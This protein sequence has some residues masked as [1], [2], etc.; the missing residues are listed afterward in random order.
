MRDVV[1]VGGSFAHGSLGEGG[2]RMRAAGLEAEVDLYV[3]ELVVEEDERGRRVAV[4]DGDHGEG[5]RLSSRIGDVMSA[6]EQF[7]GTL[8]GLSAATATRP[9][10]QRPDDH[11]IFRASGLAMAVGDAAMGPWKAPLGIYDAGDR[12]HAIRAKITGDLDEPPALR[13]FLAGQ[14]SRPRTAD[15]IESAFSMVRLC[16]AGDVRARRRAVAA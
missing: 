15:P 12:A 6:R 14:R 9:A 4:R 13:D 11:A 3:A 10:R 1:N 2:R 5:I 8:A 7:S 16:L